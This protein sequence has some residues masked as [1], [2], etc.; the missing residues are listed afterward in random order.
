MS[1]YLKFKDL[2]DNKIESSSQTDKNKGHQQNIRET[3]KGNR[4]DEYAPPPSQRP[5]VQENK[6]D[7]D[8]EI[9]SV[10]QKQDYIR[11]YRI[12]VIDIYGDFCQPCKAIESRYH[13]LARTNKNSNVILL[14]ENVEKGFTKDIKGV[15][16]FEF[17]FDGKLVD[18]MYGADIDLAKKKT[19]ELVNRL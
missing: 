14:K 4:S 6:G 5:N 17:Y 7:L 10:Q 12:V 1:S 9:K 19:I 8:I 18:E 13:D 16:K 15:P 2:G 11:R 3:I